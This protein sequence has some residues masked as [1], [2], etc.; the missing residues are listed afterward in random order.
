MKHDIL[1]KRALES[2]YKLIKLSIILTFAI[3]IIVIVFLLIMLSGI[4]STFTH[5]SL[6]PP[7][8]IIITPT[9]TFWNILFLCRPHN[10]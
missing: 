8:N 3:V 7:L 10:S 2:L 4:I 6:T 5:V 9:N 1:D